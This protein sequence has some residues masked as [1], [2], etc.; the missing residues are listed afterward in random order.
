MAEGTGK[1]TGEVARLLEREM[2]GLEE[3]VR[4]EIYIFGRKM[5]K[6]CRWISCGVLMEG[7]DSRCRPGF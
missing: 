4:C 7:E 6:A 1:S 2:V 3:V 5:N